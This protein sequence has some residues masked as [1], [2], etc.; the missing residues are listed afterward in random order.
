M[1][2]RTSVYVFVFST[3][4]M[5][6]ILFLVYIYND[7]VNRTRALT[8]SLVATSPSSCHTMS[9]SVMQPQHDLQ[10]QQPSPQQMSSKALVVSCQGWAH[11]SEGVMNILIQAAFPDRT[12]VWDNTNNQPDLVVRGID[13]GPFYE[14][15]RPCSC[16]YIVWSGEPWPV[17]ITA[18]EE[19]CPPLIEVNTF[20]VLRPVPSVFV[21]FMNFMVGYPNTSHTIPMLL[22]PSMVQ[23]PDYHRPFFLAYAHRHC[24]PMRDQIF[25]AFKSRSP[26]GAQSLGPCSRDDRFYIAGIAFNDNVKVFSKYRWVLAMENSDTTASYVSEKIFVALRAGAIPIYWGSRG[27]ILT[28][29]NPKRFVRVED[30]PTTES[31][32]NH[33]MSIDANEYA[34]NN[35]VKQ[36]MFPPDRNPPPELY[37]APESLYVQSIGAIIRRA[38]DR[39][40]E[41]RPKTP[42]SF[43]L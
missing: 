20:D 10:L 14:S 33:V 21:S 13:S 37:I 41:A 2:A 6:L 23:T 38:Y 16:P 42:R 24:V 43:H 35:I 40:T 3:C 31:L 8:A 12:V 22:S 17:P 30:F 1:L 36:P 27:R 4:V 5:T 25:A 34:Y 26:Y 18:L 29:F 39:F 9:P 19:S 32:V 15:C 11:W 7:D 28:L